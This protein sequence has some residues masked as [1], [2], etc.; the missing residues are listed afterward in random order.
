MSR[1]VV[2]DLPKDMGDIDLSTIS[3]IRGYSAKVSSCSIR[4]TRTHVYAQSTLDK[5]RAGTIYFSKYG[6]VA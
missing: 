4:K 1:I 3:S 5:I 6:H 2:A